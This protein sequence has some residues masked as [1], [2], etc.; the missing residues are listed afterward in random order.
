[1]S[2]SS[3]SDSELQ[4]LLLVLGLI[5]DALAIP[6]CI[7]CCIIIFHA[8]EFVGVMMIDATNL[9][10]AILSGRENL[11]DNGQACSCQGNSM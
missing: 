6:C 3:I 10:L 9:P 7:G 2:Y 8:L 5:C 1:M 11:L 4:S